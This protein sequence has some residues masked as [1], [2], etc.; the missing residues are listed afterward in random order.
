MTK[1]NSKGKVGIETTYLNINPKVDLNFLDDDNDTK[2]MIEGA[3]IARRI[4][5]AEPFA[6]YI[7]FEIAPG[8]AVQTDKDLEIAIKQN[9][10]SYAH[11]QAVN[12]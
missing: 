7:H 5:A 2:R 4:A 12:Q 10:A 3:K 9:V 1:P 8:I 6:Q 11:P